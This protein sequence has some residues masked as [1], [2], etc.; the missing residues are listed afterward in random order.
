MN[1]VKHPATG[2]RNLLICTRRSTS[3]APCLERRSPACLTPGRQR[4]NKGAGEDGRQRLPPKRREAAAGD[5]AHSL[6]A[7]GVR[8][9]PTRPIV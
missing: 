7:M 3:P 4:G 8:N 5:K 1:Q 9:A 6:A 2:W